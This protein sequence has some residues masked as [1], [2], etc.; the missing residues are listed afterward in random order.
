M[1]TSYGNVFLTPVEYLKGIGP[2]RARV[3]KTELEI[4][5]GG[6]LLNFLPFRYID[7]TKYY[8]ISQIGDTE[9]DVQV[10]GRLG[11]VEQIKQNDRVLRLTAEFFD[12][13]GKIELVWFKGF[14]WI[15]KNLVPGQEYVIFG[16]VSR[17]MGR[18]TMAH[19]EMETLAAHQSSPLSALVPVYSSTEKTQKSGITSRVISLAVASFFQQAQ[20]QI[21]ETLSAD[22]LQRENLMGREEALWTVHFPK[23]IEELSRARRRMKFEEL[24][25]MQ[26]TMIRKKMIR[27]NKLSGYVFHSVGD[28]FNDFY[29]HHLPFSLTEA[30]KRV[31]REIRHDVATGY[32]MNRLVQGDVGS[33]KTIVALLSMLMALDNGYQACMM[34]PTEIL[35][36]QHYN[37]I[38]KLL[39]GMNVRVEL[40]TGSTKPS[41]RKELLDGL[42][43]G[44]VNILI[45][46]H[47]VIEDNVVFQKLG[48]AIIDEQ[49]R[50]GVA[51]RSKLW[52]KSA[53]APH[54]LVMTATPIPRTLA[55]TMYGDLDVSVI[56]ELPAG[57]RPI[58]TFH[59]YEQSRL[60]VLGFMRAQIDKGRQVYVVYPLIKESEGMDYKNLIDGYTF[61]DEYFQRPKYNVAVVHGKMKTEDKDAAIKLFASGKADI[62][63]STT[64]I[65]VGV[66]IPNATVMVIESAERFGLAQLHQLRGRVGRGGE[67]SYCIL[68][69]GNKLSDDSKKR[70]EAMVSTTDGFKIAEMD[71]RLRGFGD[72]MGVRQSGITGLKIADLSRDADILEKA[73]EVAAKLLFA[74]P[75]LN[76]DVHLVVKNTYNSMLK[77]RALWSYIS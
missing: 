42:L 70:L 75:E 27:Q 4:F 20:G 40:L 51:Q 59:K 63:V 39:R 12:S 19:P 15:Q 48:I 21:K 41:K 8:T 22:I 14:T 5:N 56:D 30:Q 28:Y 66:D 38:S 7:K 18:I 1:N 67:Q 10:I 2:Q 57:R 36:T 76:S 52:G 55:M 43:T 34:A 35:A 50:F 47:A 69:S 11:R 44:E 71:L 58:Q 31:V 73:R 29:A 54:I 23:S 65:E 6:D 13:T 25:Y 3:L 64:V 62:L 37:G 16:R 46:T 9:A 32:Q 74:D 61:L 26:L 45:G 60:G 24:F 49:H 17:Y 72:M 33:G 68:M 53:F 77:G